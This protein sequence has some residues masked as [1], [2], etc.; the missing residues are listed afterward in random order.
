[1]GKEAAA[2]LNAV[3]IPTVVPSAKSRKDAVRVG[4]MHG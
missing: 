2:A 3:G 1:M 4:T